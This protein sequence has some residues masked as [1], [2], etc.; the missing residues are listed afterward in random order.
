MKHWLKH[1]G[2]IVAGGACIVV[3]VL[4][5]PAAP[6]LGVIGTKLL[7]AG[8]GITALAFAQPLQNVVKAARGR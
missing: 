7:L 4:V 5:P 6:F 3:G 1:L 8:G 2:L